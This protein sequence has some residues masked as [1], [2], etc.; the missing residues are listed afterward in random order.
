MQY[1]VRKELDVS[2]PINLRKLSPSMK[3]YAGV[4]SSWHNTRYYKKKY[5]KRKEI[6]EQVRIQKDERLKDY[7]LAMIYKELDNQT[8]SKRLQTGE[9]CLEVIIQVNSVSIY[10]LNRVLKSKEFLPYKIERI[11][12]EKDFRIAFPDMPVLIRVQKLVL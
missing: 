1:F 11:P 7:L 8:I 4:L 9:E 6:E 5:A 10:S 3:I 2:E 12:E